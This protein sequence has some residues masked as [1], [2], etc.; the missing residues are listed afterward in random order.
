MLFKYR[1]NAPVPV[2]YSFGS[3]NCLL[4]ERRIIWSVGISKPGLDQL[5]LPPPGE[6]AARVEG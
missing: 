3:F 2:R 5:L 1:P 6:N 4:Q